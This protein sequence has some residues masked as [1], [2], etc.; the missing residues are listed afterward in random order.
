MSSERARGLRALL[1]AANG[2]G[3]RAAESAWASAST[4]AGRLPKD[5][6]RRW[7]SSGRERVLVIAAHADDE[8]MGC[9]GTV[10]RHRQAGDTVQIAIVTDG[11]RSRAHGI[12]AVS[13]RR[14]REQEAKRA[15]TQMGVFSDWVGLEEG[16]WSD[17]DGNAA[18]R[19]K[20]REVA[21]TII[22][23]P[24]SVDYQPEHRRLARTLAALLA[25]LAPAPEVA[26]AVRMY[27][28]QVPLTPLLVNLVH[29]VSDLEPS[30]RAVLRAYATQIESV[31][32][33]FRLRR[34]AA[35]FH[36]AATQVESFCAVPAHVY[37]SLLARAPRRFWPLFIR[38]WLDPLATVV[39]TA[40]RLT[41]RRQIRAAGVAA[42]PNRN[43]R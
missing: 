19:R 4:W 37:S 24:S 18:L 25:E 6:P 27:A 3:S 15:A 16:E 43:V 33:T 28:V 8:A 13:M 32:R 31:S 39:G 9:A 12:D 22:Y 5:R 17:G 20:L 2:L 30:I 41:W 14:I 26:P 7:S 29:D 21:P 40:E 42:S 23:A 36:G 38:A 1:R 11:S 10:I 34:Y 35:R